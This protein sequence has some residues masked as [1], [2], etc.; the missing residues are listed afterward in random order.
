M[1]AQVTDIDFDQHD[2]R[3]IVDRI[4]HRAQTE[5][6]TIDVRNKDLVFITRHPDNI[7]R[8]GTILN[9]RMMLFGA[10]IGWI[11]D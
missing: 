9:N 7:H 11:V 2:G 10:V 1:N 3:I 8:R 5:Q 4:H 6:R